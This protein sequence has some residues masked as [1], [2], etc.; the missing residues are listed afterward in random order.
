[1]PSPTWAEYLAEASTHLAAARRSV[2]VGGAPPSPPHRPDQ[3][4]PDE[5]RPEAQRLAEAYEQL[6]SEVRLRLSDLDRCTGTARRSRSLPP[7][8]RYVDT[9]A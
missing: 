6:A 9:P 1:M 8:A 5:S 7:P 4:I 2:E 3:P